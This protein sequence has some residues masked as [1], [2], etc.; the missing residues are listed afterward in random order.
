VTEA[1]VERRHTHTLGIA[2]LARSRFG[3]L[4]LPICH[5]SIGA[6]RNA[7]IGCHDK[8]SRRAWR[9]RRSRAGEDK[10]TVKRRTAQT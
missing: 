6:G 4:G 10:S 2:V 8:G 1:E 3:S 9:S 7:R 5:A